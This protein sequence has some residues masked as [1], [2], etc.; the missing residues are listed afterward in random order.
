MTLLKAAGHET[1]L[2]RKIE[3]TSA[4]LRE[5]ILRSLERYIGFYDDIIKDS[6]PGWPTWSQSM[7]VCAAV[8]RDRILNADDT[9]VNGKTFAASG[10]KYYLD[11]ITG[12]KTRALV[13]APNSGLLNAWSKEELNGYAYNLH[14]LDPN[15]DTVNCFKDL[16]KING[17]ADFTVINWEKLSVDKDNF[18]WR[19]F[20]RLLENKFDYF[21]LD[22][23]HNAKS[24]R[25]LRGK[26]IQRII[27]YT[28]GKK[29]MLL[30]A[31]PMP[32]KYRDLGM[33]FHILDPVKYKDPALLYGAGPEIY[34]EFF[35]REIW[36]RLTRQQLQQELSLP[37]LVEK[38]IEVNLSDEEAE[39]YFQAWFD[40]VTLGEG[41]TEL[42]KV[43]YNPKLSKYCNGIKQDLS[44]KVKKARDLALDLT[45]NGEKVILKTQ[46]VNNGVIQY[47]ADSLRKDRNVVVVDGNTCVG[48]RKQLYDKFRSSNN[49]NILIKSDVD[50]ESRALTVGEKAIT[51][52]DIEPEISPGR[53]HQGIG[54]F[55][56]RGQTGPTSHIRLVAKSVKLDQLM[57]DALEQVA[58]QY[59]VK[60][61]RKFRPRTIDADSVVIREAKQSVIDKFYNFEPITKKD[62]AVHDVDLDHLTN[63]AEH[64]EALV[65]PRVFRELGDFRYATIIQARWRNLGEDLFYKLVESKIWDKWKKL[66]ENGW[67]G[68]ASETT[69][70]LVGGI[71]DKLELDLGH[72]VKLLDEGS[73]AAYFSR[74]TGRSVICLDLDTKFLAEGKKICDK[75]GIENK[76]LAAK[77]TRTGLKDKSFDITVNGYMLFY[78]G[79]DKDR[80]QIEDCILEKNRVMVNGGNYVI[81][82][83][84]TVDNAVIKRFSRNIEDYGFK[85]ISYLDQKATKCETM[86]NGCHIL[87]YEKFKD[88]NEKLGKDLSFYD[89]RTRFIA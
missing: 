41:L 65:S 83:P 68:S 36:F 31:T 15:V 17:D 63:A 34:K 53:E 39:V 29:L 75:L 47:I 40:C 61:P 87:V 74:A 52:I 44:S 58:Q 69:L 33:L 62:Q 76:Y 49:Y 32:D 21:I 51:Q 3:E 78:L 46:L 22:E 72:K 55:Y 79:Q 84:Y 10:T 81:A 2:D 66:Y 77:A 26:S 82:L 73:G 59:E 37:D 11:K 27:P 56:R 85:E 30:S 24:R 88:C 25:S 70:K 35:Q 4:R 1:T 20:E 45:A 8:D 64:L 13:I 50:N 6:E 48:A 14:C 86:K 23:C 7:R 54:R 18:R 9:G 67:K 38:N 42:R 19:K 12:K 71:V 5:G 43:L 80:S 57:M 28:I 16:D 89:G 60:I